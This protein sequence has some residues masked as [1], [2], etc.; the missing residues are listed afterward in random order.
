MVLIRRLV[1]LGVVVVLIGAAFGIWEAVRSGPAPT[2]VST[3]TTAPPATSRPSTSSPTAAF[4]V[5]GTAIL[6]QGQPFLP[7]GVTISGLTRYDWRVQ[8]SSDLAQIA[9][10]AGYWHGNTVRI[11]VFPTWMVDNVPGYLA[12]VEQEVSAGRSGGLVVVISAQYK[13]TLQAPDASTAAFWRAIAP[14]YREDPGV[15]FDLYNEPKEDSWSTWRNGSG[16][17]VGMQTLLDDVRAVAPDN[18]VLA[19]GLPHTLDGVTGDLL[20]GH[21]VVYEIHP[22][23]FRRDY[24]TPG[25][26]NLDFGDLSGRIPVLIGEWGEWEA[27][28]GKCET[29]A[30]TLVPQFLSYVR[31]H[32]IGL[33]AYA[34][35]PGLM[36]RGNNLEDPTNFDSGSPYQCSATDTGSGAQGAGADLRALFMSS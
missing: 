33:I 4:T 32:H 16:S 28:S 24:I 9:A 8:L 7:Y 27:A 1:P 23:F 26:W 18:L 19:E 13:K 30:P 34:L 29:D 14:R 20:S 31:A 10:T 15:W 21:N 35:Q 17:V 25:A 5:A 22:Y 2:S 12:A 11:Q 6:K 36:I 3:T